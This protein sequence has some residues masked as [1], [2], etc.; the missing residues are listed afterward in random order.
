MTDPHADTIAA[1]QAAAATYA[2]GTTAVPES[3][4]RDLDDFAGRV[5]GGRVLEIG[6]GPGR[7]ARELEARGLVVRRTDI[8]RFRQRV[9]PGCALAYSYAVSE[10]GPVAALMIASDTAITSDVRVPV[11]S[12][13]P[14]KRVEIAAPDREGVG[15]ILVAGDGLAG[16]Y[17]NDAEQ[18]AQRFDVD[19]HGEP[20]FR[21]GDR[22]RLRPDGLLEYRGRLGTLVKVRGYT[23]DLAEVERALLA[24][25]PFDDVAVIAPESGPRARLLAYVVANPTTPHV[26]AGK[27]RALMLDAVPAHMIPSTF[28]MLDAL[29]RTAPTYRGHYLGLLATVWHLIR[30]Q[31]VLREAALFGAMLFG[32][33]MVFWSNL[34]HLMETPAF[35]LGP[36]AVGL[37]GLL[38]AL[39]ALL[40]PWAGSL[41]DRSSPRRVLLTGCG[42]TVVVAAL[43]A[44][45][46]GSGSL[47]TIWAFLSLALF[48]MGF[49]YGPLG[50]WLPSLFPARVRYTGA[51][52]AF[53][54]G[55]ILGGALAPIVAQALADRGG[56]P[57]V[58]GYL[59]VAGIISLV[60]L[61][62]LRKT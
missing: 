56:L 2:A 54:V 42:L 19:A 36:R 62:P 30:D 49:V 55:G 15:E 9:W 7:D 39:A 50:G 41:A 21:T 14:G 17:W 8:T 23:V 31:P 12:P 61:L 59:A 24:V 40:C 18:T 52:V 43:L 6:S 60:G 47:L 28:V 4:A 25:V 1:Y 53:N 46:L 34:I 32:S 3:V 33:F 13:L 57:W 51:S 11:G 20:F 10:V 26:E 45:M 16:G 44:P 5:A 22:G 29:P 48:V 58:G 27:L 38:G 35:A 37:Y